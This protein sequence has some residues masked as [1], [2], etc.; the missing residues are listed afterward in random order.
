M[1]TVCAGSLAL[2]DAGVKIEKIAAGVAIGLVTKY[3]SENPTKVDDY[4]IL[5]DI[6]VSSSKNYYHCCVSYSILRNNI[7]NK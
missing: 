6:L 3:N 1:A 4:R 2:M 7:N 5:I